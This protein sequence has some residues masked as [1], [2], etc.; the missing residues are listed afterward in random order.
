M[1]GWDGSKG[2]DP[3]GIPVSRIHLEYEP[4]RDNPPIQGSLT[5]GG[6][7]KEME[8]YRVYYHD[9]SVLEGTTDWSN[10]ELTFRDFLIQVQEVFA[11]N[12]SLET[13]DDIIQKL[14][15]VIA[16]FKSA[17]EGNRPVLID[18]VGDYLLP[19]VRIEKWNEIPG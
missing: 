6:H 7:K 3:D 1:I 2:Y 8:W 16:G 18:E 15:V 12:K 11:T 13:R 17:N 4:R 10:S 5:L 14:K 19:T 9:N